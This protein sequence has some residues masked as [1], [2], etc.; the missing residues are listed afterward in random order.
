MTPYE[1]STP[2][3]A[4]GTTQTVGVH[5]EWDALA[6]VVVG[7]PLDFTFPTRAPQTQAA[8]AFLPQ[9]FEHRWAEAAGKRWSET[10]PESYT[11]C[12]DQLDALAAFLADRDITVHRP[13]E[14]SPEEQAILG[15]FSPVSLQIFTRD[16]MIV[17]GDTVIEASL[18]LP[19]RFKERFGLR[20][21]IADLV[22]RGAHH[23]VVP[24]GR[25][26]PLDQVAL[27]QGPF[28]EGGDVMLFGPDILVGVGE[29]RYATDDAGLDWLRAQLG[30]RYR[31]HRVPL[32]SRVL[33]LD[34]GLAAVREGLAVVARE[35][36]THGLPP[37]IADWDLIDV[38]LDDALNLLAA[39]VL[40]LAPGEVLLDTRLPRLADELT[41]HGVTVHT[42]DFDAVTPFAGGF[43]CSHHPVRRTPAG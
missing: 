24:P 3:A 39:N 6:E 35:Q 17:I 23:I 19:H 36:F 30:S 18:R 26:V 12:R 1:T 42:M 43:R 4:P 20:P 34:D 27:A 25:P 7:R 28:L 33:H 2:L 14:L 41:A 15:E 32:H 38:T 37:L 29:G 21:L 10:D 8:L 9:G 22:R 5:R 11:R 13:V 31:V 16:P 40:V